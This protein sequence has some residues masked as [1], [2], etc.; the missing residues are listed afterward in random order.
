LLLLLVFGACQSPLQMYDGEERSSDE[1]AIVQ[2]HH[3]VIFSV[4]GVE[5]TER[6]RF[7]Q[8]KIALLPGKHEIRIEWTMDPGYATHLPTDP[9]GLT[10]FAGAKRVGLMD[11]YRRY[12]AIIPFEAKAGRTYKGVWVT[13]KDKEQGYREPALID[14]G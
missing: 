8:R 13:P 4:D 12:F 3:I 11:R 9:R 10:Y 5:M 6:D 1:V 7:D 14:A 2:P